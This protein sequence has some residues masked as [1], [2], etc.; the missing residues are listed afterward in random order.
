MTLLCN[1]SSVFVLNHC[2]KQEETMVWRLLDLTCKFRKKICFISHESI[3]HYKHIKKILKK[4]KKK[5]QNNCNKQ[6]TKYSFSFMYNHISKKNLQMESHERPPQRMSDI[7]KRSLL[8]VRRYNCFVKLS[9]NLWYL[10]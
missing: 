9:V 3:E 7:M 2:K 1:I 6:E 4:E 8:L 5:F 10:G